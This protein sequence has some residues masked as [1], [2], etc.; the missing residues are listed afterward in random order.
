MKKSLV[1]LAIAAAFSGSAFAQSSVTLYGKIDETFHHE[2]KQNAAGNSVNKL[3]AGAFSGN[4]WGLKGTED[5]GGGQSAIFNLEGGYNL[6]TG[7]AGQGGLLFGRTAMVGLS[8]GDPATLKFGR[9]YSTVFKVLGDFDPLGW[10][11][12]NE[13]SWQLGNLFSIRLN[14]VAEYSGTYGPVNVI[15][16][17]AFGGVAGSTK[18]G[19]T[20]SIGGEGNFGVGSV[21]LVFETTDDTTAAPGPFKR[22]T[23]GFG[24]QAKFGIAQILGTYAQVNTD[25]G[26]A[27]SADTLKRKDKY[28]V[29]GTNLS[30]TTVD[31]I[32]LAYMGDKGTKVNSASAS[33]KIHTLYAYYDH[34]LSKRTDVYV[35]ID[36]VK[37]TGDTAAVGGFAGFVPAVGATSVSGT[38]FIMGVRHAF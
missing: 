23:T 17:H 38:D 15:V 19:S 21:G 13:N 2:P 16:Q 28:Y 32:T 31:T 37:A 11:N 18:A 29:I 4:R 27:G 9:Q 8:W 10:G 30:V 14:N 6:N 36:S 5:L 22:S 3:D 33:G 12:S 7:A 25:P 34:A 35:G 24:A 20:T 26:Y 1:A